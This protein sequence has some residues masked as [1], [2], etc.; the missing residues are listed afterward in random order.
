MVDMPFKPFGFAMY[1]QA[2]RGAVLRANG[3]AV[4][5]NTVLREGAIEFEGKT[6]SP[7]SLIMTAVPS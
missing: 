1:E 3:F 4:P 5:T 7:E 6:Y 2:D